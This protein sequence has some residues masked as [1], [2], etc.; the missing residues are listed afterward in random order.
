MGVHGLE[1]YIFVEAPEGVKK[2]I[3]IKEEIEYY[4]T[5]HGKL[6]LIVIDL[7]YFMSGITINSKKEQLCG[8]RI[9]NYIRN[10]ESFFH[11]LKTMNVEMVFFSNCYTKDE[12]FESWCMTAEKRYQAQLSVLDMVYEG[13]PLTEI[14]NYCVTTKLNIPLQKMVSGAIWEIACR[15]GRV[16]KAY[17][18]RRSIASYAQEH[19]AMAVLGNNSDYL[20]FPGDW[21]YWSSSKLNFREMVT[22]EFDK[23]FLRKQLRL[24][25]SQMPLF[26]TIAGSNFVDLKSLE[27]L[28]NHVGKDKPFMEGV[29]NMISK[30]SSSV[31]D[32]DDVDC[33][34]SIAFD[35]K[36]DRNVVYKSL[37]YF[38]VPPFFKET[39]FNSDKLIDRLYHADDLF[40]YQVLT[41]KYLYTSLQ[42]VDFRKGDIPSYPELILTLRRKCIG[43]LFKN[44]GNPDLLQTFIVKMGHD[45][46]F[47]KLEMEPIYPDYPVPS[48][49]DLL[50][51]TVSIHAPRN[52]TTD[53]HNLLKFLISEKIS[54]KE[55]NSIHKRFLSTALTI[56]Y[57]YEH[58]CLTLDEADIFTLSTYSVALDLVP[59]KIV[60]PET[61][62]PRAFRLTFMFLRLFEHIKRCFLVA[63][64]PYL[65]DKVQFDGY[66]LHNTYNQFI[67]ESDKQKKKMM[68]K[69][70][71]YVQLY[72][73]LN[74]IEI[75]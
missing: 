67:D 62:N 23:V 66:H 20:I 75:R 10:I 15:N 27:T 30:S 59:A 36:I 19:H 28:H 24:T 54:Q 58:R 6:P 64:L 53:R 72:R 51:P 60:P 48:L 35:S 22:L 33:I 43:I 71:K 13:K 31:L 70:P 5:K 45:E 34:I 39:N 7:Q 11:Q 17:E 68:E 52:F 69:I 9:Q 38:Q 61:L 3:S 44:K 4:F 25:D 49:K 26:A 57:M 32:S 40:F 18:F 8:G 50:L 21:R 16:L 46:E 12:D 1:R 37:D 65:I 14:S 55:I 41:E 2:E 56:F 42:F 63:G 74:D 29:A 47:T 73:I